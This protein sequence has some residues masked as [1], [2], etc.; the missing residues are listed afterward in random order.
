M[1]DRLDY[2]EIVENLV[3]LDPPSDVASLEDLSQDDLAV[4]SEDLCSIQGKEEHHRHHDVGRSAV[5]RVAQ[6]LGVGHLVSAERAVCFDE[7]KDLMVIFIFVVGVLNSFQRASF[8]P[9]R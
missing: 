8:I 6:S 3:N 1:G 2:E 4:E 9:D 5:P 7:F